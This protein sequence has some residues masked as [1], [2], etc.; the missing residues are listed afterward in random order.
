MKLSDAK[1]KVGYKTIKVYLGS[2]F[3]DK[4][5]DD[6][7]SDEEFEEAKAIADSEEWVELRLP[8]VDEVHDM[9]GSRFV[10]PEGINLDNPNV[11]NTLFDRVEKNSKEESHGKMIE[12]TMDLTKKLYV[13]SS[14]V[15]DDG[16]IAS[17]EQVIEVIKESTEATFKLIQGMSSALGKLTAQNNQS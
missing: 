3:M 9:T 12:R 17:A 14:F 8:R 2:C 6:Y 10:I 5:R 13:S 1:Q 15:D 16:K 7:N 11:L 4:T